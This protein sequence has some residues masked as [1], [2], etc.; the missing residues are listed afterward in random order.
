[1]FCRGQ[2]SSLR[3]PSSS[4]GNRRC[5]LNQIDLSTCP[6]PTWN[7][8]KAGSS[9]GGPLQSRALLPWFPKSSRPEFSWRALIAQRI[10]RSA[11]PSAWRYPDHDSCRDL[12]IN[13]KPFSRKRLMKPNLIEM[14]NQWHLTQSEH[15]TATPRKC[16]V[17]TGTYLVPI[18]RQGVEIDCCPTCRGVWLDRGELERLIV[19]ATAATGAIR[20]RRA[21]IPGGKDEG[22]PSPAVQRHNCP[23]QPSPKRPWLRKTLE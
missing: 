13:Q 23:G 4:Y 17:C 18:Q 22:P 11:K 15:R 6:L 20:I 9:V 8:R 14:Q 7:W 16:P 21:P 1:M 3:P 12:N 10:H 5:L 2:T 19:F